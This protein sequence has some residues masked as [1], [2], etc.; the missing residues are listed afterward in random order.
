MKKTILSIGIIAL[1][2]VLT[3][4]GSAQKE[5]NPD[6]T[7]SPYFFVKSTDAAIDQLPLQSTEAYVDIAGVIANV[8]ILQQYKNN[9]SSPIEAIY[10][11]PASTRAALHKMKMTIGE[12]TVEAKINE[13]EKARNDYEV[14]VK[15]G[16]TAS[17]LEEQRPNVFQMNVGNIMPGDVI[18]VEMEY[19]ELLIPEAGVYSFVY[20]TVVGPRYSNQPQAIASTHTQWVSNPYTK[21]GEKP[22]YSFHID[23][24][25]RAGMPITDVSCPSHPVNITYQGANQAWVEL[26]ESG[27]SGG[28]KDFIFEYKL[29]GNQVETGLLLFDSGDEKFFLAMLQ[30][31]KKVALN[32]I[33][34]REYI[35]IV[36]VSGSMSG[37]PLDIS[38][39]LITDLIGN[40]RAE[41]KFNILTFAGGSNLMAPAS[42]NATF[43]NINT[44][45]GFLANLQGG[46]GTELMPALERALG[47]P[48]DEGCS[49]T[50]VI[51]TD[52]YVTVEQE[53][54]QLIRNKLNQSNF[55]AFGIGSA[56]NRHLIEGIAY[57]GMGE[58]F[59]IAKPGEAQGIADR[60]RKYI[61]SPVLTDIKVKFN[62]FAAYDVEPKTYPD[63]FADRPLIIYGKYTGNPEGSI[64][65]TG[66]HGEGK[67]SETL[68]PA[69]SDVKKE[70]QALQYL[71]A[72]ERIRLI[73]DLGQ[74]GMALADVSKE[75]TALGMKYHLLTKY[76]SFVAI[77]SEKRNTTGNTTQV[78]QPL[79]LPEGVSNNAVGQTFTPA[80]GST[81]TRNKTIGN[82]STH[83][84]GVPVMTKDKSVSNSPQ[85]VPATMDKK[86]TE[87]SVKVATDSAKETAFH[88][89]ETQASYPGGEKAMKEF[90]NK[91]KVYPV[92]AK[93]ANI[94]GKVYLRFKIAKDGS[95][96]DI[97]IVRGIANGCDEEAIRILKLMPKWKPAKS[98]KKSVESEMT[99]VVEF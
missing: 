68:K 44:A 11:F 17:L 83:S 63:V 71:W 95:I 61:S 58:S 19:T 46:G 76:T 93:N 74:K 88:A 24:Q 49:R 4:T 12:R 86:V 25:L 99:V 73:D 13:R 64:Q 23:C 39:K 79:P 8:R 5:N 77:D 90:I 40:L 59:V 75:V 27:K 82:A 9:G 33:P 35:F 10:V 94:H 89:I 20:P 2:L 51:A 67:Y 97:R 28:N 78:S 26:K 38:K 50:M 30:P 3:V 54:F 48:M 80:T 15:N 96:Q 41:D 98:G 1:S 37:F 84:S 47:L 87:E 65:V 92:R 85:Y 21:E 14:A 81:G 42:L 43:D 60:F 7:E 36:D 72:R 56:V 29:S 62:G 53:A 66:V 52:G 18:K 91:N 34:P 31:P 55:F 57:A 32:M 6:K 45:K 16:Q 22:F 69:E 70:N